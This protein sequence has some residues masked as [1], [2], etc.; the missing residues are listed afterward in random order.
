[1]LFVPARRQDIRS[2]LL[3]GT[4]QVVKETFIIEDGV[5]VNFDGNSVREIYGVSSQRRLLGGL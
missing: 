5:Y 2:L 1:M 4:P 3:V